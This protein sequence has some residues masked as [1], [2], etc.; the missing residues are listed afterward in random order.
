M[1]SLLATPLLAVSLLAWLGE[2]FFLD[3][4]Q[5]KLAR[6]S[7]APRGIFPIPKILFCC[8]RHAPGF[9]SGRMAA[10]KVSL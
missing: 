10:D 8:D 1:G 7:S 2:T 6:F 5:L 4:S 9:P 3:G